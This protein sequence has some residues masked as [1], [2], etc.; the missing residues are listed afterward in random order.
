MIYAL[1][2][3][4]IAGLVLLA[5]PSGLYM[6]GR[7]VFGDSKTSLSRPGWS[8]RP[9]ALGFT[10]IAIVLSFA[11]W[12]IFPGFLLLPM[13]I[14]FVWRFRGGGGRRSGT[15]GPFVWQ[16]RARRGPPPTNGHSNG[17]TKDDESSIEGQFRNI[18]DE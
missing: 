7:R 5:I 6:A 17:H 1:A 14:P 3:T 18:D 10:L 4:V 12:R 9:N 16:W 8:F 11:L 15:G 2:I 13:L